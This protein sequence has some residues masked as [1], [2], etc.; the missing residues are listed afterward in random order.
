MYRVDDRKEPLYLTIKRELVSKIESRTWP[1]GHKLPNEEE[2]QETYRVSR[3]TV[4]RALADLEAAGYITRLAAKGTFVSRVTP[5]LEKTMSEITSFTQQLSRAG[6]EPGTEVLAAELIAVSEA[7]GRVQEGFGLPPEAQVFRIRRVR[8]GNGI[9]FAIQ[10]VYLLPERCPGL[11]NED[12]THL[13]RLYSEKYG[14]KIIMANEVL[15]LA[16]TPADSDEAAQL[17]VPVGSPI[18][19][20][21]RVS[22]DQDDKPFEVLYSVDRG[23]MFEY[24]YNILHDQVLVTPDALKASR[25]R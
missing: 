4:R 5:R 3:G 2:L 14:C 7:H 17:E 1:I 11:L 12:L 13:F 25:R 6:F 22:Y 16:P 21:E 9:P 18:V 23:D 8:K 15:R 20:R 19:I 24:R 10:T